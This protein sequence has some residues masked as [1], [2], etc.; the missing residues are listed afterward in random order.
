MA[1]RTVLCPPRRSGV[2]AIA[3]V[4]ATLAFAAGMALAPAVP[5]LAA[6]AQDGASGLSAD[7]AL[8]PEPG[9][10]ARGRLIVRDLDRASCLICHAMPIP[11]E[12]DHGTIGPDLAGVG[13]RHSLGAL[14]QRLIDPRAFNPQ[15]IMP[16]YYRTD[17]LTDVLEMHRGRTI[18]TA[19]ELE[20]V[21]A[22]LAT[23]ADPAP[24]GQP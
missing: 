10:P 5:G 6:D 16:S 17:G 15:T 19:Q 11:E 22:Y 2:R 1:G 8:T 20:D 4:L 21:L 14:R 7:H 18:Y 12:P 13:A 24:A 3:A 23:L 9:N